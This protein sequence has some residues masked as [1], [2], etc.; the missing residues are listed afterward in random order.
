MLAVVVTAI[1]EI[2]G[3]PRYAQEYI[4]F[5]AAALGSVHG[6]GFSAVVGARVLHQP[7]Q[8]ALLLLGG[9]HGPDPDGAVRSDLRRPRLAIQADQPQ[10]G[11][12]RLLAQQLAPATAVGEDRRYRAIGVEPDHLLAPKGDVRGTVGAR[13]RP[14]DIGE[15]ADA[16]AP[17][18][19]AGEVEVDDPELA[20]GGAGGAAE[21]PDGFKDHPEIAGQRAVESL[22]EVSSIVRYDQP[23]PRTARV[24]NLHRH[25]T[26]VARRRLRAQSGELPKEVRERHHGPYRDAIEFLERHRR[27]AAQSAAVAA[28]KRGLIG[29]PVDDRQRH[30]QPAHALGYAGEH[31]HTAVREQRTMVDRQHEGLQ[32]H[33][34]PQGQPELTA[35]HAEPPVKP[36]GGEP[37]KKHRCEGER[38]AEAARAAQHGNLKARRR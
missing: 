6:E 27:Q 20:R 18:G 37:G 5:P 12:I 4:E 26:R 30:D 34:E 15:L 21:R 17:G 16:A 8:R 38:E 22:A 9:R 19:L 31:A 11:T 14:G 33:H 1:A 32:R 24:R 35:A 29:R 10:D 7:R 36:N 2:V 3:D 28:E 23:T 25:R 13:Y